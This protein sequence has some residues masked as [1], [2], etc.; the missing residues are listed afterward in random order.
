[1][2]P[3]MRLKLAKVFDAARGLPAAGRAVYLD[4]EC[5]GEPELRH[6]IDGLLS[7]DQAPDEL[8]DR[9]AWEAMPTETNVSEGTL[10]GPY[11]LESLLGAGGMGEVFRATDTRLQ[12]SVAVK[13]CGSLFSDRFE[14]EARAIAVLNHPHICTLFDVG[15]NYLVMELI[16]GETLAA[17]LRRGALSPEEI[18]RYGA[19]ISDALAEAHRLGV[20][21]RDLKPSNIMLTR[22]GIKVLD[23]G[24]AKTTA[25]P[26][27]TETNAVIGT[28]AYMAPEQLQGAPVDARSD[29]FSLG[30]VLYEMAT[31][32]LPFPGS[33]LGSMINS[34]AGVR[35]PAPSKAGQLTSLILKL[36]EK[37]PAQRPQTAAEVRDYLRKRE[38]G[39]SLSRRALTAAAVIAFIAAA[40][41]G[42]QAYLRSTRAR[43]ARNEALPEVSRLMRESRWL[44][45]SDLLK[46]AE[47]YIPASPEL[48]RLKDAAPSATVTIQTEPSGADIYIRDYT[49]PEEDTWQLLGRSPLTTDR[50]PGS[51]YP[52][53]FYRVRAVKSGFATAEWAAALGRAGAPPLKMELRPEDSVPPGMV[54]VPGGNGVFWVSLK[55][56]EP[57][58]G[59][60]IDRLEVTNRQFKDF[61]DHGGYRKREY[62]KEPFRSGGR[63][64]TWEQAMSQFRD[65]T[66]QPGPST[67]RLSDY[68][69]GQADFPVG[70]V[71]WY[72]AAA[73]AEFAGKSLPTAYHWAY[74]GDTG[75]FSDAVNLGNFSGQGPAAAGK[76][77]ALGPFGTL[78]MAGNVQ[79]W[80]LN[81]NGE[82][83]YTLGGAWNQ[84]SY[85][86][87]SLS[88]ARPPMER[89]P[90]EGFRCVRYDSPPP[91]LLRQA[92]IPENSDRRGQ[93]PVDD[94]TYKIFQR[95]HQYDR[96]DLNTTVDGIVDNAHWRLENVSFQAAYNGERVIAHLYLPKNAVPPYQTVI[97]M[98]G[99][100]ILTNRQPDTEEAAGLAFGFLLR[101]GRAV[102][103]PVF[104]G[105][106]ERG[107]MPGPPGPSRDREMRV[108]WSKDL[109]RTIDYLEVRP[110]IDLPRLVFEGVSFGAMNSPHLVALE[111]RIKALALVSGG[112]DYGLPPEV[113]SWNYAPRVTVPVL[114]INGRADFLF[115]LERRQLPLLRAFGTPAKD[116]RHV[117][118]EGGHATPVA[119]PDLIKAYLD[120]LD[121][122]FGPV[123]FRP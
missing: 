54:W 29:L 91:S 19:Q 9:P 24:I 75:P 31:G 12:R 80:V 52:R 30:L 20:I 106:T 13:V 95:L 97:Y 8:L 98:G 60:W 46:Q 23:F 109:G 110:D 79:E 119:Q 93:I 7:R 33:S 25:V 78:D 88:D 34:S 53:G 48:I 68:P 92:I 64:L 121:Q 50:L 117:L 14:R 67:W 55:T 77:R 22:N 70:G 49:G 114:M 16:E 123:K 47:R 69:A 26:G 56:P 65:A 57:I 100:E 1:M 62:W 116:K 90:Y 11:R 2:T 6:Q 74:A 104:K 102:V 89:Q 36:L 122:Y 38:R 44:A 4:R 51:Y 32:S 43:W 66:G 28:P 71:S 115:P 76:Y 3:E 40:V 101:S 94:Q 103:V 111:P 15:P 21:H 112:T 83:R 108:D 107:P 61:V 17:R 84:P 82:L 72:E 27:L 99:V 113:D 118:F 10:L 63:P 5:A 45:A 81:A 120:W 39:I 59:F 37:D 41:F 18:L 58:P 87:M 105:T 42:T 73:Y 85:V 96:A 35:I 86:T